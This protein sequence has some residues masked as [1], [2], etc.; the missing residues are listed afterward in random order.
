MEHPD[1]EVLT[2]FALDDPLALD[3]ATLVHIS[4]CDRCTHEI[5]E[6]QRVVDA[7]LASG[8]RAD[9]RTLVAPPPSVFERVLVEVGGRAPE[10]VLEVASQPV[11][12]PSAHRAAVATPPAP[13]APTGTL[14]DPIW[15]FDQPGEIATTAPGRSDLVDRP[16]DRRTLWQVTV[17]GLVGLVLGAGVAWLVA[18]NGSTPT[19]S[20]TGSG[21]VSPSPLIG[22]DGNKTSGEISLVKPSAGAPKITITIDTLDR[23]HGFLEAWLVDPVGGG[24]VALG[25]VDGTRGTFTVPPSLNRSKYDEVDVSREPFDGDPAHSGVSLARGT[26]PTP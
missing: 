5:Q 21:D 16:T 24:M 3:A 1:E 10:P 11:S 14:D 18:D 15:L 7:A 25:V 4:D 2:Q 6:I 23:G 17:A 22:V 12:A 26:L 8:G 13:A 9:L 20:P 19:P